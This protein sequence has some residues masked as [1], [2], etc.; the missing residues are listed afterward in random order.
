MLVS[1]PRALFL[2][3][4]LCALAEGKPGQELRPGVYEIHHFGGSHFLRDYDSWPETTVGPYGVCDNLDNL[5]EKCPELENSDRQFVVT[6]T[7]IR[8]DDQP[9]EGGWRWHKWGGYI[10]SQDTQCEYLYD[11]P[12]IDEV[13]CFH[14]YEKV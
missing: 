3:P 8:K 14:I 12:E 1:E 5:L 13:L 10:G 2:D 7:R 6:L 9:P 11:E 4:I